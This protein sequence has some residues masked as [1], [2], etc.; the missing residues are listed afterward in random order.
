MAISFNQKAITQ[1]LET[2]TETKSIIWRRPNFTLKIYAEFGDSE[3]S[4][5]YINNKKNY[6]KFGDLEISQFY[7]KIH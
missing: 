2:Y 6:A 7:I 5:F 1:Q 3:I 4:Q